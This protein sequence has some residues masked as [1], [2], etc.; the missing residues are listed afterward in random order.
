MTLASRG[1]ALTERRYVAI[2]KQASIW[3]ARRNT[4][5]VFQPN[6]AALGEAKRALA[7]CRRDFPELVAWIEEGRRT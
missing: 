2:P 6:P 1:I 3:D 7:S 4:S 5:Q